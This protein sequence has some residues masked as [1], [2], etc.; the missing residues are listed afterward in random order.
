[1]W[2][3]MKSPRS[4]KKTNSPHKKAHHEGE[5][6]RGQNISKGE[7]PKQFQGSG[8]KP[9]G[10]FVKKGAPLK[11]NQPKGDT[12]GKPKGACFNSNEVGHYSNDCPKLK[13][14][15]G[16]SKV[17]APIA[18]LIQSECNHLMF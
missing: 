9:K 15:N 12:N 14:S 1:M 16:G 7:N 6:N 4:K 2:D 5:W 17:I 10:N 3:E 8:F 11:G 13:L 18:N